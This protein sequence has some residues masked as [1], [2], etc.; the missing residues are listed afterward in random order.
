[1]SSSELVVADLKSALERS[2]QEV[3]MLKEKLLVREREIRDVA[4]QFIMNLEDT[5]IDEALLNKNSKFKLPNF[6][7]AQIGD[8]DCPEITIPKSSF[9]TFP[10]RRLQSSDLD[11][12]ICNYASAYRSMLRWMSEEDFKKMCY[13][14]V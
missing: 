13:L 8:P 4:M 5:E 6:P 9:I 1:M 14:D 2:E 7:R 10:K 11:R 3:K 12:N